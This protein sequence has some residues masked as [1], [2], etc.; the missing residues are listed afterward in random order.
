[1]SLSERQVHVKVSAIRINNVIVPALIIM[2]LNFIKYR[3]FNNL[4]LIL[5]KDIYS[6][7][8]ERKYNG[9]RSCDNAVDCFSHRTSSYLQQLGLHC[10][11]C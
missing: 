10:H 9:E 7:D 6:L 11:K 3:I 2:I 1:M 4:F 8:T 5:G